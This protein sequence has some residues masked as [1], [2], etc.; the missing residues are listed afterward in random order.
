MKSL[1]AFLVV[2]GC[3]WFAVT[4]PSATDSKQRYLEHIHQLAQQNL[5][6]PA[7]AKF[8]DALMT[9][10]P[11]TGEFNP[12]EIQ[13]SI[14]HL[15]QARTTEERDFQW[16][17]I[18]SDV[19]GRVR[20]MMVDPNNGNKL[21]A[22][23][24]TGGLWYTNDF[25]NNSQ[26]VA[27][28]DEWDNL[29]ISSLAFD[30]QN[31]NQFYAGTGESYT[32]VNM[33]RESTS[34]GTGIYQSSDGGSS[35]SLMTST[36]DFDYI[37][38]IVV[39]VEDGTSVIYA[40][41]ASG[42]YQGKTYD[43]QPGDGL[44]RSA[45]GGSTWTQVLPN[46]PGESVSF[47]VSDIE[48]GPDGRIF[49]GTMRNLALEGGGYFLW[50]DD[51]TSWAMVANYREEVFFRTS[52]PI[53]PGRVIISAAPSDPNIVYMVGT[54]GVSNAVD[55]IRDNQGHT[56]IMRSANGGMD[57]EFIEGPSAYWTNIPWHALALDVDP[58]NPNKLVLGALG[59]YTLPDATLGGG[60]N[61]NKVAGDGFYHHSQI[62]IDYWGL[63]DADSMLNHY[64][65]PDIH[66]IHFLPGSSDEVLFTTDGGLQYT[67]NM[68]L[69]DSGLDGDRLV[70]YPSFQNIN[71]GMSTTQYYTAALSENDDRIMG[72][73]QDNSTHLG[74]IGN[75]LSLANLTGGGD[76]AYCYF[77]RDHPN[78]RIVSGQ[79]NYYNIFIGSEGHFV[80]FFDLPTGTFINPGFYDDRSNLL[81]CNLSVDGG[82]E[83]LIPELTGQ[84]LDQVGIINVNKFLGTNDQGLDTTAAVTLGTGSTVAFSALAVS[85]HD[86]SDFA[87]LVVGNQLGDLFLVTGLPHSPSSKRIDN[88]KLPVG[89]ISGVDIGDSNEDIIVTFSNYGTESVWHTSNGGEHWTN[90][91]RNLPDIPVR[92]VMF[93][94]LDDQQIIIATELG[95]WGLEGISKNSSEWKYYSNGMPNVRV[96]MI[97]ARGY[98]S[99]ILAATHG[100]GLYI[101]KFVQD[102]LQDDPLEVSPEKVNFHVY[103]NPA[104]EIVYLPSDQ[105][106]VMAELVD[107]QGRSVL[108]QKN[109]GSTIN[110]SGL[111]LGM[112]IIR[113]STESGT[114]QTDKILVIR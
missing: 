18:V 12:K 7:K 114:Q 13:R 48:V 74:T 19:A 69:S 31:T 43:S 21:W 77:D 81:Y 90:L 96:D 45:D 25:R 53:I 17:S 14:K 110:V 111:P 58:N 44:Y 8:R 86:P 107:L 55:Q 23:A 68:S 39:R 10:N 76:G 67:S 1:V 70:S 9:M 112:Y 26:W 37:N 49:V 84:F 102:V 72:G 64:V 94:P 92:D 29:S 15:K 62:L 6:G 52:D 51:G 34:A 63:T 75:S 16:N 93:N 24:A 56:I 87:T 60:L 78:V 95:L 80:R 5:E 106:I 85:P 2:L 83:V 38:D 11:A 105:H 108:I 101:G 73:A 35:W 88:N 71:N 22:G 40:A 100:R 3:L 57:W 82:F 61:W 28:S 46:I 47:A 103:P 66:I 32:S 27:V 104:S 4:H 33:Y 97:K 65:H 113:L 91:D 30:P 99:T 36:K 109:P 41:V 50:S 89:Y 42:R 79:V 20:A 54:S 98:D 59:V